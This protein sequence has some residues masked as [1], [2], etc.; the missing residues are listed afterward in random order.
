MRGRGVLLKT[1]R[2][3]AWAT[4]DRRGLGVFTDRWR[5][6]AVLRSGAIFG[7]IGPVPCWSLISIQQVFPGRFPHIVIRNRLFATLLAVVL[8]GPALAWASCAAP[9]FTPARELRIATE[10]VLIVTHAS[11]YYDPRHASKYG[12]DAAVRFAK[13]R[14]MPVIYLVDDESPIQNYFME[15]CKPT[16]W[17]KSVDG[18]VEFK[19]RS[20][21]VYLA[22]GHLELCLARTMSDLTLQWSKR[23]NRQNVS[24]EYVMD[25]IYSNGKLIEPEDKFYADFERFMGVVTYGRPGGEAWPK[26]NL[27]ETIGVIKK[28]EDDYAYLARVL[29]HWERTFGRE[30]RVELQLDDLAVRTLQ[31]GAGGNAPSVRFHFLDSIELLPL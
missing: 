13:E 3:G 26:L 10:E 22:G 1:P 4:H 18:E 25:G 31:A 9:R 12:V 5:P 8:L 7:N 24:Y 15:D 19:V 29:P 17:V 20:Q 21:R 28:T 14:G 16:H 11:S 23:R 2:N 6:G 27:L 30:V